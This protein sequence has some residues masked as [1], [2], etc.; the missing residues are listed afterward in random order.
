MPNYFDSILL[1]PGHGY[2]EAKKY[3]QGHTSGHLVETEVVDNYIAGICE[4]LDLEGIRWHILETR[5]SPGLTDQQRAERCQPGMLILSCH[6]GW[7]DADAKIGTSTA[8]FG[9]QESEELA[10]RLAKT[11]TE[12]GRGVTWLHAQG[13]AEKKETP[14][15][16]VANVSVELEPFA[17][18]DQ[19]SMQ[20]AAAAEKLGRAVGKT[21]AQYAK[22]VSPALGYHP[23]RCR[24]KQ[25]IVHP[26]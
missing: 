17:V 3:G 20:Y 9:N 13:V 5:K 26:K 2:F 7:N 21:V 23:I 4:E 16:T 1:E 22:S 8:Y 25:W 24:E 10:Q 15:L 6:A 18:N 19:S 12:W 11:M 14:I